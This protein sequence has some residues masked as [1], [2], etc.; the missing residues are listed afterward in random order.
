[1]SFINLHCWLIL[2][3]TMQGYYK[4]VQRA[5]SWTAYCGRW[6]W[7]HKGLS[8]KVRLSLNRALVDNTESAPFLEN[9]FK[10]WRDWRP[11][12]TRGFFNPP[13][14]TGIINLDPSHWW[15]VS[16]LMVAM[17]DGKNSNLSLL[18][19]GMAQ[20]REHSPPTN[21]ARVRFL[22][23]ASYVGWVCWISTLHQE[24]FLRVLR[25]FPLL[26]TNTCICVNCWFQFTVSLISAWALEWLGT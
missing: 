1:M 14:M 2:Y 15:F 23:P 5:S 12:I 24:V 4:Y 16:D 7:H 19:A 8:F 9:L 18:C 25:F 21:V 10:F 17:L 26:K 3:I 6:K 11:D 20:W 22:V 13:L